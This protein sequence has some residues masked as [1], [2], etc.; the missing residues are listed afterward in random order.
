MFFKV[1]KESL[2]CS[3]S[4]G[5]LRWEQGSAAALLGC[6]VLPREVW[7]VAFIGAI[8]ISKRSHHSPAQRELKQGALDL[9]SEVCLVL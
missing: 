5:Q 7:K 6:E 9:L 2:S 8:E 3:G 1:P 4:W